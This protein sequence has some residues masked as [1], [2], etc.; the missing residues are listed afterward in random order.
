MPQK[1]RLAGAVRAA[2]LCCVLIAAPAEARQH[3]SHAVLRQ[4]QADNPCPSTG[5]K[6]GACPGY[7]KD[8]IKALACGGPDAVENLQ[9]QTVADAKAKDKVELQGCR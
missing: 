6:M 2:L 1:M 5:R 4:F 7:I 9:W 8:H 3:R